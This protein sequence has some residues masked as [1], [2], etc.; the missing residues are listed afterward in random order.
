MDERIDKAV[1]H[2]YSAA[3]TPSHWPQALQAIAD[4]LDDV[5]AVLIYG[6]DDG[7]FGVIHSPSLDEAVIEYAR[8]WSHRDIRA[9]RSRE[10][11]YFL[12]RDVI[13]D[14]DVVDAGEEER[15]PFYAEFLPKHGLRYFAA[16]V[17]SP[18]PHVEVALSLQR[19]RDRRAYTEAEL[20]L[21]GRLGA[22]V[23]KALRVSIRLM[24]A[25][26]VNMGLGAALA[27]IGISVF[28]IDALGRIVFSNPAAQALIGDAFEVVNERLRV[29]ASAGTDDANAEIQ[30]FIARGP[31]D[32]AL[33]AQPILIQRQRSDRPLVLYLLPIAESVTVT[34]QFL[35][36]ARAIVLVMDP[37]PDAPPDATVLRDLL[38]LTLGEA[39]VAAWIG[40]GLPPRQAAAKLGISEETARTVLKRVFAKVG[41][42]RQS[43][44]AALMTKLVLR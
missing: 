18:D 35:T 36:H 10:R 43:E 40:S 22:H 15:D 14:R 2:I 11:G 34:N 37:E 33:G 29:R 16:A 26:L 5:G 24:D 20:A 23:E 17:V 7:G 21:V 30:R 42:S 25:E 32:L 8:N 38:G 41:V 44:L 28:A 6:R 3:L 4:C 19:R 12:G 9:L 27:R 39:R 31:N 13:T 1:E